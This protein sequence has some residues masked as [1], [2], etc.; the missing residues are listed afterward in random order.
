MRL[1]TA[2]LV[3]GAFLLWGAYYTPARSLQFAAAVSQSICQGQRKAMCAAPKPQVAGPVLGQA[4]A[5]GPYTP[6]TWAIALLGEIGRPATPQNTVAVTAWER[7]EGGHWANSARF[8][9]LNTT[10]RM[11]GSAPMNSVGVQAYTSW[12]QGL[13]ATTITLR[14]GRYGGVLQALGRGNCAPC[15]ADAVGASPWGTGRFAA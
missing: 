6:T 11:P 14:N 10:Q 9:P 15:V 4:P 5:P 13:D 7:A 1:R 8:N 2:A 12:R 3:L